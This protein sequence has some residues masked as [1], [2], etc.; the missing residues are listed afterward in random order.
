MDMLFESKL[1]MDGHGFPA[2]TDQ[3]AEV[4]QTD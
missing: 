1:M 3:Q 2:T 4:V